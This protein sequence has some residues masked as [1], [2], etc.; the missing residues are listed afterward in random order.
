MPRIGSRPAGLMLR[1]CISALALGVT[2][3]CT[4]GAGPG[5]S[6]SMSDPDALRVV[7]TTTVLADMV[8]QVGGARVSVASLV[9][10]GGEVHTFDPTPSDLASVA[11]ADLVVMNGLGLDEWLGDL[12]ADS[13]TD[14][15]II[16]LGEDLD[17]VDYLSGAT[18]TD[19]D[20]HDEDGQDEDAHDGANPHLWLDVSNGIRYAERI[21]EALASVDPDDAAAYEAGTAAYVERLEA[22]DAWAHEQLAQVPEANRRIVSFHEAFPYFA[23]AYGLEIVGS[24][25][26]AP[27]QDPSAGEIAE[28]VTAIRATGAKA[29]FSEVQFSPELAEAVA[30]EAGVTVESN[31][32]N[33]SLGGEVDSYEALIRWDVERVVAALR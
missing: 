10:P 21:G 31:L 24:V 33:D 11:D 5:T 1:L 32:Y 25:I 2:A 8:R 13:G 6:D 4:N 3:G 14:A 27:G 22:L 12:A 23:R 20:G 7:A 28:L 9:P 18:H 26:R 19:E 30:S 29:L 17:G 15:P 16:E